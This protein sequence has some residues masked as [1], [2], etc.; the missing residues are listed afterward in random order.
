M[1][2]TY[3]WQKLKEIK[4]DCDSV[5]FECFWSFSNLNIQ[6]WKTARAHFDG[7]FNKEQTRLNGSSILFLLSNFL[8]LTPV[9]KLGAW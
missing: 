1:G 8:K 2:F 7:E 9:F 6:C 3:I 4:I 5:F